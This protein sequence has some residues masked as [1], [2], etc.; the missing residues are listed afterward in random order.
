VE[1]PPTR[2]GNSAEATRRNALLEG[3]VD[4][5]ELHTADMSRLPFAGAT[6]DVV[7]NSLALHHIPTA[8][9]RRAALAEAVR[10][11]RPGG[12][13]PIVDLAFTR[14][15]PRGCASSGC[16]SAAAQAALADV[17]GPRRG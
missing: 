14:G 15:T 3:V 9:G 2:P 1:R 16:E 5:V 7:V 13:L 11:W 8:A 10:V 6:F 17:V 4:P 12:R